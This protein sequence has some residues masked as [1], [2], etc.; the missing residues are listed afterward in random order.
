VNL[1]PTKELHVFLLVAA[2]VF[3]SRVPFID[4]GYGNDADAW[5]MAQTAK[6]I[7]TSGEYRFSRPFGHPLQEMVCAA[8]WEYGPKGLNGVTALLSAL[9]TAFFTLSL[10]KM[11]V[12]RYFLAGLTLAFTPIV[13]IHSTDL[14]DYTW[15]LAFIT[16]SLYFTLCRRIIFAGILLALAISCKL[17][18]IAT[19]LP[20]SILIFWDSRRLSSILLFC[21]TSVLIGLATYIPAV[22]IHRGYVLTV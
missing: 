4:Y 19:V 17:T 18:S 5:G 16:A 13:W 6:A 2:V 8:L 22:Q 12:R 21:A 1:L 9:G 11:G 20:L 3:S 7:G 15:A 14:T 10:R